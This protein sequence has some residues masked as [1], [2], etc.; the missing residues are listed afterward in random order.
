MDNSV[1]EQLRSRNGDTFIILTI[2]LIA[3]IGVGLAIGLAE[4]MPRVIL[5][6]V[7]AVAMAFF[8]RWLIL[9][10]SDDKQERVEVLRA[11]LF[12]LV[13]RIGLAFA[14]YGL[15]ALIDW[16]GYGVFF[17]DDEPYFDEVGYGL[18][19]KWNGGYFA[20]ADTN[21]YP[22]V[23]FIAGIYYLFGYQPL[24]VRIFNAALSAVL[25]VL[26]FCIARELVPGS[27]K[28]ARVALRLAIVS[29]DVLLWSVSSMRDIQISL[30]IVSFVYVV[31]SLH[32]R[33]LVSLRNLLVAPALL[34]FLFLMRP[35]VG[36][37]LILALGGYALTYVFL[38]KT[39]QSGIA[40]VLRVVGVAG[41]IAIT[42]LVSVYQFDYNFF[43]F[44]SAQE[45]VQ[46]RYLE[47]PT[48]MKRY[49]LRDPSYLSK[50]FTHNLFDLS[51]VGLGLARGIFLPNPLWT[52][53]VSGTNAWVMFL[54]GVI[55]YALIPFWLLGGLL[56]LRERNAKAIFVVVLTLGIFVSGTV[57]IA[58]ALE[59][60]RARVPVLP[61]FYILAAYGFAW[62]REPA[63]QSSLRMLPLAYTFFLLL[64]GSHYL[65]NFAELN[66]LGLS[67]IA[68]VVL[69]A[70]SAILWLARVVWRSR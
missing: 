50:M 14:F 45:Y 19:Q 64:L 54:P 13:L 17:F 23:Y 16:K 37:F 60:D 15:L 27:K 30:G 36:W 9:P 33:P 41:I 20:L 56:F 1:V 42:H 49:Y 10:T 18:A 57:G 67:K 5:G 22:F 44:S 26:I 2:G 8:A 66:I 47:N 38:H 55:W 32:R 35:V 68:V 70:V 24:V 39:K 58:A 31:V 11:F 63:V 51:S 62:Y 3:S 25:P 21:A 6:L 52:V 46:Q 40:L 53:T 29:P 43:D 65:L 28:I 61:F 34:L 7:S 12:A 48:I 69:L 4:A 59:P